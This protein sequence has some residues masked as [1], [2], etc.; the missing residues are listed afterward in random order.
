MGFLARL[1]GLSRAPAKGTHAR[2]GFNASQMHSQ[3]ISGGFTQQQSGQPQQSPNATRRELLRVVLRDTM[4]RH[5]VPTPW[6][7]AETLLAT[8]RNG[9]KGIHWRIVIK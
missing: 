2:P 7:A 6:V 4:N 9:D 8:S 3:L 5:G 1:F